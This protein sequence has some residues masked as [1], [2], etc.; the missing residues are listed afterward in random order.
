MCKGLSEMIT[1]YKEYKEY[2]QADLKA[3]GIYGERLIDRIRDRRF[4]FYRS[5][6][7]N[8]Y[9]FNNRKKNRLNLLSKI[10]L[11][12]HQILC[13][14]YSWQIPINVFGPGLQIVHIG[15][16]VVSD[17]ARIGSNCRLHVCTN[18]G[19]AIAKGEVS[20][21]PVIGDNCYVGPGAKI[22][23][24]IVLGDNIAIG[25]NEVVNASFPNG[26]C[27]IAGVPAKIISNK[28]SESYIAKYTID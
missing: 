12:R 17:E 1:T 3:T 6:R 9:L 11:T 22:F 19:K 13:N 4:K 28:T 23:G 5:L 20:G 18:I 2:L 24:G 27:T 21:A 8:E 7:I 10:L 15:T 14:K 16:I 25:A 26:N